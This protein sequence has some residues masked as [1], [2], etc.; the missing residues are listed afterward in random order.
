MDIYILFTILT[1]LFLGIYLFLYKVYKDNA[2]IVYKKGRGIIS[3]VLHDKGCVEYYVIIN[4][5]GKQIEGKSD[6]Y[7]GLNNKYHVEDVV[8][9]EYAFT[10]SGDKVMVKIL[11]EELE[12][13]VGNVNKPSKTCLYIALVCL[14]LAIITFIF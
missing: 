5:D 4:D 1:V 11:D 7:F 14:V 9:I 8:D 10:R 3:S 12:S 6:A 2:S 13:T